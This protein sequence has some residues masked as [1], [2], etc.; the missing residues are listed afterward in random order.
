MTR[1][2]SH[3]ILAATCGCLFAPTILA[4][5]GEDLT[6][7][8]TPRTAAAAY[9]G[10][11]DGP[12]HPTDSARI[13]LLTSVRTPIHTAA[14]D[15]DGGAYGIWG[16]GANY[17]A[18]FHDGFV[19][20]PY[21]GDGYPR[22]RSFAWRTVDATIGGVPLGA[23]DKPQ[24]HHTD[25]RFEYR[26]DA[27]VEAYDIGVEGCEQTFV[28]A[29]RPA[30]SGDLVVTGRITTDLRAELLVDRHAEIVFRDEHGQAIIHY[31]RAFAI[32]AK[33]NRVD[34][35]TSFDG[36]NIYLRV[37][38]EW[39]ASA[40]FPL[41]IDPL[42]T[43][44]CAAFW[45]TTSPAPAEG[46]VRQLATGRDDI[47]NQTLL[48]YT[49][50]VS[51]LDSDM[52]IYLFTDDSGTFAARN[53]VF[54]DINTGWG[55]LSP[56][57]AF[58]GGAADSWICVF[59]RENVG[60]PGVNGARY[61]VHAS[62]DIVANATFS[63]ISRP[64]GS[65]QGD[66]IDVGGVQGLS[67]DSSVFVVF[68]RDDVGS[69]REI[70]GRPINLAGNVQGTDRIIDT[71]PAGLDYVR[72][73]PTINQVA[74]SA[75][76][77][78]IVA[79]QEH[80]TTRG[81]PDDW[82]I[83]IRRVDGTGTP[84]GGLGFPN[85]SV[86]DSTHKMTP[87]IAGADGRYA[88]VMS[89]W[90]ESP[91]TATASDLGTDIYCETFDFPLNGSRSFIGIAELTS[92]LVSDLRWRVTDCA[93]DS[94]T[95]SHWAAAFESS[96][97][98]SQYAS[99]I[100]FDAGTIERESALAPASGLAFG[101]A[102]HFNDDDNQFFF[103]YA[104][105]QAGVPCGGSAS[106]NHPVYTHIF[107]HLG[108]PVVSRYGTEC[109]PGQIGTSGRNLAGV[110]DYGIRLSSAAPNVPAVLFLNFAPGSVPLN[111][112][113]MF[114]CFLNLAPSNLISLPIPTNAGGV[115]VQ[116]VSLFTNPTVI[117]GDIYWQWVY[118][119]PG[120]NPLGFG[121]TRGMLTRFLCP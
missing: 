91:L 64:A 65:S 79:W 47:L 78:W 20:V 22:N 105:N 41:T 42:L 115:A 60:G 16:A 85:N 12:T 24:P 118:F 101:G 5:Q 112:V 8:P 9:A 121:A 69:G 13:D 49:R 11:A 17:K 25:F 113:G 73:R 7:A 92:G 95:R 32:D 66:T 15:P 70:F 4:Q 45:T 53:L 88:L 108:Q 3:A 56:A 98:G 34:A 50:A 40:E 76:D 106:T 44:N 43:R 19:F 93:F 99:T 82:D 102:V 116:T 26:S 52:W 119:A 38:G 29:S 94:N 89:T 109:G 33:G 39:V 80:W 114:G 97:S 67:S 48:A 96:I 120:L 72:R 1:N 18:S 84:V 46:R 63:S 83:N 2:F 28:I 37:P 54:S 10:P 103:A 86:P 90:A 14:D 61:H 59:L 57:I 100:G 6:S 77:G 30:A 111:S 62:G 23:V 36:D 107:E 51:A 74:T 75:A 110:R 58:A 71:Q 55:N 31:G 21:L 68:E 87:H 117:C 104:S 27:I 81:S 35:Y